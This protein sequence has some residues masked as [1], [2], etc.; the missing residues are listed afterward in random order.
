[1]TGLGGA[2]GK[3]RVEQKARRQK[4][5]MLRRKTWRETRFTAENQRKSPTP[6]EAGQRG[7]GAGSINGSDMDK[8]KKRAFRQR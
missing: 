3:L 8:V 1:M 6:N 2:W 4:L 5:E 7:V